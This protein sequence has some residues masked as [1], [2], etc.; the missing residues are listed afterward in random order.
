MNEISSIS[1]DPAS[2]TRRTTGYQLSNESSG[3]KRRA[4]GGRPSMGPRRS[5]RRN[6]PRP[7]RGRAR[8][9][10]IAARRLLP[11]RKTNVAVR[12][13][14]GAEGGDHVGATMGLQQ[15]EGVFAALGGRNVFGVSR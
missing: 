5:D 2:D 14:R 8:P 4:T 11:A 3:Q 1:G 15:S 9:G 7:G 6:R 10:V 13:V 12:F